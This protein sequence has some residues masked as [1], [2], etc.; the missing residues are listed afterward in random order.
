MKSVREINIKPSCMKE[1]QAY[2]A[3]QSAQLWEKINFLVDDPLPDG[4]LKKKLH[5][6]DDL[7]RL[8]VGDYRIFYS[9]GEKWVS[10]LGLRRRQE[11]TYKGGVK[12]SDEAFPEKLPNQELELDEILG[13]KKE[14]KE[15][16][17][18]QKPSLTPLPRPITAEWLDELKV[19]VVYIPVLVSCT[20]EESLLGL[21]IPPDILETVV[22]NIFP[23]P[24][25]EVINQP[26][27][28]VQDIQDLVHYKERGLISFLLKLDEGQKRL[29]EWAMKGPTLVKGGAGTGKS[30]VA[31]Y[32]V[33]A[34]L[35]RPG[36]TGSEKVFFTTYTRSLISA[37]EQLLKQLLTPDQY[38]RV[39][40]STCDQIAREIVVSRRKL[41]NVE[42]GGIVGQIFKE[43]RANFIV[44]GPTAFDRSLRKKALD[45]LSDRYLKEE[46]DWILSGRG[47]ICLEEYLETPRTGRGHIFR[48][49]LRETVW[50]LYQSF[51]EDV[52]KR[53]VELFS[54]IRQEALEL[55]R[56]GKWKEYF[57]YIVVDEAQDL[58]PTALCLMAEICKSAQGLFFASDLKQSIYSR[59]YSWSTVHPRL[60]FKGRTSLLKKNYRSTAE[61]DRAAFDVLDKEENGDVVVS[62]SIHNGTTPIL[63]NGINVGK[64]GEWAAKF[65]RQISRHLRMKTSAAAILVPN[66]EVGARLAQNVSAA[67]VPAQYFNGRDLDLKQD[68]VKIITLHSAK[69]LEFPIVVI[70]GIENGTYPVRE[71][72]EEEEV[73][74]ERMRHERKL[75]YVGMSRAMRGLMVI[76]NKGCVHEAL[77]S[78]DTENWHVEEVA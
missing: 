34:L 68:I 71:D 60:Q 40:V 35:E 15:F 46:F 19:P 8:R 73:Y 65:I 5:V 1:I 20:S 47:I 45:R 33:K 10:L 21:Q 14:K 32:R 22:D 66:K 18:E 24:I 56:G 17:F 38:A 26:D 78:L 23:Q 7:Y 3:A 4:K 54:D 39:R 77:M 11:D 29:T 64:Q 63:L 57:D 52:K 42:Q 74:L 12:T 43:T 16:N 51:N 76:R 41:G 67:G 25:E 30:T 59:N 13:Q 31:L 28:I 27:L 44:S 53:G 75:L 37:S 55:V 58:T 69:G 6:A 72:F 9:F 2:P 48:A 50:E 49:G 62:E 36:A 61:I 70:C